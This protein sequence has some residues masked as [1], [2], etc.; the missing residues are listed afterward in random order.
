MLAAMGMPGGGVLKIGSTHV[1]VVVGSVSPVNAIE[2]PASALANGAGSEG[3]TVDGDRVVPHSAVSVTIDQ[4]LASP[5]SL[6]GLPLTAD[7]ELNIEGGTVRVV[8]VSPG[9]VAV[10]TQATRIIQPGGGGTLD[11]TQNEAAPSAMTTG[12]EDEL[13]TL[14]GW[15]QLVTRSDHD[16]SRPVA[17]VVVS[18]PPGCGARELVDAAAD[19]AGLHVMA[20]ELRSVTTAERLLSRLETAATAMS[21][22]TVVVVTDLDALI[23]RDSG[24]Q[25]QVTAVLRW[26]LE[27]VAGS[28]SAVVIVTATSDFAAAVDAKDLLPRTVTISPPSRA[29]RLGLIM[30]AVDGS[31]DI[32]VER[33]ANTTAGFS[34]LDIEAA[35]LEAR[36]TSGGPLTTE[37]LL[38][39]VGTVQPSLGTTSLGEVPSYGFDKV[40][41]LVEVKR[42]LTESVIWQLTE[43]GRFER[44]GI[45]APKG[46]LL[47][48]PPG[49]GKTFVIRA[50]AH[51]SGAAF[52]SVKGAELLDKWVGESERGVREVF[53]RARTVAP[54]IIFFDEL[55]ALAPPRGSSTNNV[56]DSV[57]AALLTELDGVSDRGDVFAIGATNRIDLIDPALLRPGRLGVHVLLDLPAPE[58]RMAFLTMTSVPM[59]DDVDLGALVE[60]T[61]GSSFADL[62]G[63]LRTAAIGALRHDSHAISVNMQELLSAIPVHNR[64]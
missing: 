10:V 16:A 50:L 30:A 15:L 44:M 51:E 60:A 49:T 14:T 46:I 48:G 35:V 32:D 25:H 2:L 55:D 45:E 12:L 22:D 5:R 53:A 40:A 42:V 39:A 28:R 37:T 31:P 33:L 56:T 52:F 3:S 6:V 38:D 27:K 61:Q 13:D 23:S 64:R 17:G 47:H 41:N 43:P 62:E 4:P 29:R 63:M 24:L 21:D 19:E 7:D 34:A 57:V 11:N 20:V 59:A 18:A 9:P 58:A 1:R 54:S 26:F 8:D 36:A